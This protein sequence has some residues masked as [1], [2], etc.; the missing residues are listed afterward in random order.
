MSVV[1]NVFG[2]CVS[3]RNY[4]SGCVG[5]A[6]GTV[7]ISSLPYS[8]EFYFYN[9]KQ[10]QQR[11]SG[12]KTSVSLVLFSLFSL[13]IKLCEDSRC[14]CQNQQ[15][16][17]GWARQTQLSESTDHQRKEVIDYRSPFGASKQLPFTE[18]LRFCFLD[19]GVHC[20]PHSWLTREAV[21]HGWQAWFS[22]PTSQP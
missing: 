14:P 17:T 20:W 16:T 10:Q 7:W 15:R 5:R 13:I 22:W 6:V 21:M 1:E 2:R 3:A 11:S 18:Q 9:R 8:F 12:K 19:W 4:V